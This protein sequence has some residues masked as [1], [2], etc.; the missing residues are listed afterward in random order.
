MDPNVHCSTVYNNQ[1]VG[2]TQMS[3]TEEW[4]KKIYIYT[5]EY[6]SSIKKSE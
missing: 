4:I 5:R 2:A 6:Y 3:I 1:D